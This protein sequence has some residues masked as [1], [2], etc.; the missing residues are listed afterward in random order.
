M[1][2]GTITSGLKNVWNSLKTL[3]SK[4]LGTKTSSVNKIDLHSPDKPREKCGVF[5]IFSP[6]DFNIGERFFTGLTTIQNR[7]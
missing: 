7:G 2:I 6:K 3:P 4:I 1:V 5:G